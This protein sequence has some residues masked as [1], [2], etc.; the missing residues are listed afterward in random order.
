MKI[1][2]MYVS[3]SKV[4]ASALILSTT[5][6]LYTPDLF[7][8]DDVETL[9]NQIYDHNNR[10]KEIEKEIA[11]YQ[12]ELKKVGGE[13]KTLQN[14]VSQ[15]EIE[16]KKVQA[17]IN[18]TQNKIGATDL[19]IHKLE[20]EIDSTEENIDLNKKAI[21]ETLQGLSETDNDSFIE[22]LLEYK[23]ISE[24]W[25]RIDE[26]EQIRTVM[27]K[28]LQSLSNEKLLINGQFNKH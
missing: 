20:I 3:F 1:Q 13:K 12:T 15:L 8:L 7:A 2:N 18:Y 6:V 16:R 23:N 22:A 14:A 4:I 9:K 26:L 11:N 24:F 21:S 19:E 10:L 28:K 17:D 27:R 5:F 25:G